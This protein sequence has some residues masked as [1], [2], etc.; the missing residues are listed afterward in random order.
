MIKIFLSFYII[1][2]IL[3]GCGGGGSGG[4][5]STSIKEVVNSVLPSEYDSEPYFKYA[6]HFSPRINS[7]TNN[8]SINKEANINIIDAWAITKGK[9]TI[10]ANINTPVKIAVIDS[11]FNINHEDYKDS[12]IDYC[13][14]TSYSLSIL[15]T[16]NDILTYCDNN[17]NVGPDLDKYSHG[18]AVTSFISSQINSKGLLGA[19]PEAQVILIKINSIDDAT[20]NAA[21]EYARLKGA[22]VINNSWGTEN[23]PSPFFISKMNELKNTYHINIVFS[24]GNGDINTGLAYNLDDPGRSDESEIDSVIG[25]GATNKDNNITTYSNYGS[26]I[27]II[28]PGGETI[29]VL[30]AFL[31]NTEPDRQPKSNGELIDTTKYSFTQGTSFSAPITSGVIALMISVNPDITANEVR[32][33]LIE[34]AIKINSDTEPY[35]DLTTDN[36]SSTFNTQRAY[37][38]INAYEAVKKAQD[39]YSINNP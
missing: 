6:W 7:F 8:N 5:Q 24:S 32:E 33:I 34:T 30:G 12:V 9:Y 22:K 14:F 39:L 10:G 37:G 2:F 35:I 29:G 26:N 18:T 20:A 16:E 23:G 31:S 28:A 25:V 15:A 19:A 11:S 17:K 13:D 21:F 4:T 27:D 3:S 38:K 36:T 1:I